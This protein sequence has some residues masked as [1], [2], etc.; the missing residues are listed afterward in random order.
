MK[1]MSLALVFL[2]LFLCG[3]PYAPVESADQRSRTIATKVGEVF[4]VILDADRT[5]GF[6]WMLARPVDKNKIE[7]ICTKY[8]KIAEGRRG[9]AGEDILLF[10]AKGAGKTK[11]RLKYVQPREMNKKPAKKAV[12]TI[13]INP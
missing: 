7:Y 12:F 13:V 1:R 8:K 11:V 10:R 3:L 9:E 5:T 2:A 4:L 6:Q